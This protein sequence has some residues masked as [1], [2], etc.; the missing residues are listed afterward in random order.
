[1]E[2]TWLDVGLVLLLFLW[3][4]MTVFLYLIGRE[5]REA[6]AALRRFKAEAEANAA[7]G[8]PPPDPPTTDI[9]PR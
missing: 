4:P 9:Q 8:F 5:V 1:M 7:E 6:R 2:A 3:P